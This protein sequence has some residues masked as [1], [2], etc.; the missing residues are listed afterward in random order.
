[1]KKYLIGGVCGM[2]LLLVVGIILIKVFV[3]LMEDGPLTAPVLPTSEVKVVSGE[4]R[5]LNMD[6]EGVV[7]PATGADIL[8]LNRWA[9]WCGPCVAEMPS[10]GKLTEYYKGKGVRVVCVS[11]EE[12][13]D[14]SEWYQEEQP[15]APLYVLEDMDWE[16]GGRGIPET[17]VIGRDG[18]VLMKHNRLC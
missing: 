4:I 12:F 2:A 10:L 7:I 5:A 11:E 15:N 9:T 1:M 3:P 6:G 16:M 17:W 18:T 8:V 14:V 13:D